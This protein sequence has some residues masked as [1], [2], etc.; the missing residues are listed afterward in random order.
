MAKNTEYDRSSISYENQKIVEVPMAKRVQTSFIEY[1]MSVI[2]S[3]ALPD[4]RD[5]LKPVHRRILYAMYE[6][7]LTYD[8][9]FCKSAATVGNVLGRYHPHGDASVYDAMVR[10]AQTFSMRYPLIDGHGNFGNV[11]GD[12]AAAYRYTEARMS[13]L[14]NEMLSDIDKNVVDFTPNFDNRLQEPV[15]L[16]SRFPNVLVNGSIGIAVGMA[17]NIPPHNLGEVIDGTIYYMDNPDASV[18]DLMQYIKGPDFP[19]RG[20]I[21]GTSGLRSAYET[22]HGRIIVRARAEV[23]EEERNII[24]TEIPYMVNKSSLVESIANLVKDK[25]IEGITALRDE[26]G[27]AGMRIVIEYRRDANGQ[28]ILNQLYKYTQLQDTCAANMIALVNGEPKLLGLKEI[29][30]EYIKFQEEIIRRRTQ[31][32]LDKANARLHILEGQTIALNN[33]EEVIK[34]IRSAQS[35]SEARDALVVRFGLTPIQAQAIVDMTLGKLAGLERFKIEQELEEKQNLIKE[36]TE[37]L[38]SEGKVKEIIKNELL[39]LKEKYADER[40]TEISFDVSNIDDEDLIE[41]H[42]CVI[43][44]TE[45]GYIKNMAASEYSAQRRGGQG[46]IGLRTKEEDTVKEVLIAHSHSYLLMFTNR[47]RVYAMKTYRI[48]ESSKQSKGTAMANVIDLQEGEYVTNVISV[49]RFEE[50]HYFMFVTKK[51]IVKKTKVTDFKQVRRNGK[52]AITLD[53][54]DELFSVMHTHGNDDFMIATKYGRATVFNENQVRVMGRQARGV[55]GIRLGTNDN[56][57]GACVVDYSKK[58]ILITEKGIGKRVNF[59]NFNSHNRG[60]KGALC[61][62]YNEQIGP[63]AKMSEV[64]DDDDIIIITDEG[65]VIRTVVEQIPVYSNYAKGV[66]VMRLKEGE[67]VVNFTTVK[68]IEKEEEEIAAAIEK[69]EKEDFEKDVENEIID[70]DV[71]EESD[72]SETE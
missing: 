27:K 12:G 67:K 41:K 15:V 54:D 36:L 2:V 56:V 66:I 64:S 9:P 25:K 39:R 14:A 3:R 33:I 46:S 30:S 50:E 49:P 68:S 26:S 43:T 5:G 29:L 18:I 16:P 59:E 65:T 70:E 6:D 17:T 53:S 22:G 23:N 28:V 44:L 71:E 42:E 62:K 4:V 60:S 47:G 1:A 45:G 51:G 35:V 20:I 63:L 7:K 37:V 19:T 72:T 55:R 57:I 48:P 32:D 52:F 13:K 21:C 31:F 58:I 11:D 38:E 8:R 24:V 40:R 10:L 69:D 61:Y 34:T